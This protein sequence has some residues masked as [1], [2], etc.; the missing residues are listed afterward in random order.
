MDWKQRL[1]RWMNPKRKGSDIAKLPVR[2]ITVRQYLSLSS[3]SNFIKYED[4]P[5][6]VQSCAN[7]LGADGRFRYVTRLDS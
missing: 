4:Y 2:A 6:G 5:G 7:E 1:S 3:S